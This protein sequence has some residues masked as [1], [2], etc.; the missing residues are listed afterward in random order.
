MYMVGIHPAYNILTF[1]F[2][3]AEDEAAARMMYLSGNLRFGISGC[4]ADWR[5]CNATLHSL[6]SR[7]KSSAMDSGLNGRNFCTKLNYTGRRVK[8]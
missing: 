6:A 8:H 7:G 2:F 5:T 1:F 3:P 4:L